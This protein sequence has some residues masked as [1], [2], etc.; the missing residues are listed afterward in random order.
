MRTLEYDAL[1]IGSGGA[2]LRASL[3]LKKLNCSVIVATKVFTRSHSSCS[4]RYN[5]CNSEC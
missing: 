1:V 3:E 2:G 4:G 5:V